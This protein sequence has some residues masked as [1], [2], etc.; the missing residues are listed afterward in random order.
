NFSARLIASNAGVGPADPDPDV[1]GRIKSI[2]NPIPEPSSF[3]LLGFSLLGAGLF[4]IKEK[5]TVV[6]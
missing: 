3:L 1:M 4:R 6:R 2:P 5:I